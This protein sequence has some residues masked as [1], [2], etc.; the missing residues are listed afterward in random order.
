MI[1]VIVIISIAIFAILLSVGVGVGIYFAT[2]KSPVSTKTTTPTYPLEFEM[3]GRTGIEEVNLVVDG[4]SIAKG[5]KIT[6]VSKKYS[7]SLTQYPTSIVLQFTNDG[8][9]K[10]VIV[11]SAKL[12]SKDILTPTLKN[13]SADQADRVKAGNFLW[14]G[15]YEFP[16]PAKS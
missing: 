10:D 3:Y 4:K 9:L 11:T 6:T 14:Q 8:G 7:Y 1:I 2:R 15:D 13:G 16:V 5:L 12:N